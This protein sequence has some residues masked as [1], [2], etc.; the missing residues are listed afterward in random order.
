[1]FT[2]NLWEGRL[3][4]H[5]LKRDL[6]EETASIDVS[7]LGLGKPGSPH[8]KDFDYLT[9]EVTWTT[10]ERRTYSLRIRTTNPHFGGVRY[11]FAC[12]CCG[13]RVRKLYYPAP[14]A[15]LACR[16]C[17]RLVYLLQYN[18]TEASRY[19][20]FL[21]TGKLSLRALEFIGGWAITG[22]LTFGRVSGV[23]NVDS[24]LTA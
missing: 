21:H 15:D 8:L 2:I 14:G 10:R 3:Q 18:K 19:F 17:R 4:F 24:T 9:P 20:L 6:V 23:Q 11:W 7:Q 12:P 16:H 5:S 1:M 22:L 13:L